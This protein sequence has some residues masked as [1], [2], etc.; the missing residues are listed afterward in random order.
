MSPDYAANWGMHVSSKS[1]MFSFG[2]IIMEMVT[3][4]RNNNSAYDSMIDSV[5]H[6]TTKNN[7]GDTLTILV[8]AAQSRVVSK[9]RFRNT[10]PLEIHF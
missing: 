8:V 6:N 2:V 7:F 1:N 10:Q 5:F 9:N 3:G 4:R